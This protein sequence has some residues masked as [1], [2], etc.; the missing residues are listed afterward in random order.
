MEGGDPVVSGPGQPVRGHLGPG[1]LDRDQDPRAGP[2]AHPG[3]PPTGERVPQGI[4]QA[5]QPPGQPGGQQVGVVG[6]ALG[7]RGAEQLVGAGQQHLAA[8]PRAL[9]GRAG[10]G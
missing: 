2:T 7:T 6:D 8:R 9:V 4:G 1:L 3:R 10:R 5:C